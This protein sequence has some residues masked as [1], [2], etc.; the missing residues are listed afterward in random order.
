MLTK[1]QILELVQSAELTEISLNYIVEI[2]AKFKDEDGVPKDVAEKIMTIIEAE[3][4]MNG[5]LAASC[6][7]VIETY[8]KI[9]E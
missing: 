5:A 1:K 7:E 6:D 8:K 9:L 2:L 3:A 4:E